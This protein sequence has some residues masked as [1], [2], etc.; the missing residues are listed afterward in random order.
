MSDRPVMFTESTAKKIRDTVEKVLGRGGMGR[1]P[2]RKQ[3][4]DV[5]LGGDITVGASLES[6]KVSVVNATDPTYGPHLLVRAQR[7]I[8]GGPGDQINWQDAAKETV[9]IT[10][11]GTINGQTFSIDI[12]AGVVASAIAQPGWTADQVRDALVSA[13]NSADPLTGEVTATTTTA[14]TL[15]LR[16]VNYDYTF[17]AAIGVN[18]PGGGA[19]FTAVPVPIDFIAYPDMRAVEYLANGGD[20]EVQYPVGTRWWLSRPDGFPILISLPEGHTGTVTT[21]TSLQLVG[22]CVVSYTVYDLQYIDGLLVG[23]L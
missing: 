21:V 22:G 4:R 5:V 14:G 7:T 10:V 20:L 9:V 15:E 11:G 19:T 12:N 3:P 2:Y 23:G 8:H 1:L 18:V 13:W 17:Q 16:A 6:V